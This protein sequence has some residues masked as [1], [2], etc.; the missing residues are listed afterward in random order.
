MS[1]P[2]SEKTAELESLVDG[3]DRESW[4]TGLA[5]LLLIAYALVLTIRGTASLQAI[6]VISAFVLLLWEKRQFL[7]RAW[8]DAKWVLG[9]LMIFSMWIFCL[10]PFWKEPPL[11]HWD[12]SSWEVS[13]PWFSLDLWRRDFA[14]PMLGMICG[15]WA[16]RP[17]AV[18][19]KLWNVQSLFVIIL[20]GMCLSQYYRGEMVINDLSPSTPP[21]LHKGTLQVRG[22]SH[23]NIFFSYVL[24]LIS[25]ALFA[26]LFRDGIKWGHMGRWLMMGIFLY[27]VFLN[28]RRGT[29]VAIF[30]VFVLLLLWQNRKGLIY[31]FIGALILGAI[32]YHQRPHWFVRSYDTIQIGRVEMIHKIPTLLKEHP[33]VGVGYGKESVIKNYWWRIQEHSHN[34]FA[35]LALE[36][37]FPGLFLWLGVLGFYGRRF[38][39]RRGG[40]HGWISQLGICFLI[41]FSIRNFTDDIWLSSNAELFWF[42][43]GVLMPPAREVPRHG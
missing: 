33:W 22:F 7:Q 10:A 30:A 25:P 1:L 21:V 11:K 38:W 13:Q 34:S 36:V 43:M 14:Q 6:L 31:L 17:I 26:F 4:V 3:Y 20:L 42:T 28:K 39:L 18:K 19:W 2:A 24:V 35:N 41:V 9:P 29:W 23:D 16:F 5:R 27:L 8:V 12:P 40:T 15:Y 37:G 32:A